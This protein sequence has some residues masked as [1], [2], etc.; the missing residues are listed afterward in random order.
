MKSPT[1]YEDYRGQ[2]FTIKYKRITRDDEEIG[3]ENDEGNITL[4]SRR[5]HRWQAKSLYHELL[6]QASLAFGCTNDP[7]DGLEE[8]IVL[9]IE[10]NMT[11]MWELNPNVFLW[12][13]E[14][15]TK[16]EPNG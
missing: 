13:H 4:N 9:N 7:R 11:R 2:V 5:T 6:H 1:K 8:V 12:I 14:G 3:G 10:E 16:G 15:L